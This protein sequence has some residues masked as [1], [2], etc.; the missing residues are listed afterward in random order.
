MGSLST[1]DLTKGFW[2]VTVC[3]PGSSTTLSWNI[4]LPSRV[5]KRSNS[6]FCSNG[7]VLEYNFNQPSYAPVFSFFFFLRSFQYWKPLGNRRHG[8]VS[9]VLW[10]HG[11]KGNPYRHNRQKREGALPVQTPE[12]DELPGGVSHGRM[13]LTRERLCFSLFWDR[14]PLCV[15]GWP[16][17]HSVNR[18]GL[19]FSE[20]HCL[21]LPPNPRLGL[22][23]WATHLAR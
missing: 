5:T 10:S 9:P 11:F 16:G 17:S 20:I 23:G 12:S 7:Y 3:S 21:C 8:Q 6:D 22:K 13:L 14:I 15:P 4:R 2:E 19:E 18:V 1:Y